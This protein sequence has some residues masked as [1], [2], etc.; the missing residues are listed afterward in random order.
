MD[1]RDAGRSQVWSRHWR[2]EVF[3]DLYGVLAT[4]PAF[5]RT[6]ADVLR[7]SPY[8]ATEAQPDALGHWSAYPTRTLR[9]RL[10]CEVLRSLPDEAG[11]AGTF[12]AEADAIDAEW[13]AAHPLHAM[14]AFD[15]DVKLVV[16]AM[17]CRPM[18]A[19]AASPGGAARPIASAL[20]FTRKM[21]KAAEADAAQVHEREN[22][23]AEDVRTLFAS[24]A[25]AFMKDPERYRSV[26]AHERFR[27]RL[28]K[29]PQRRKENAMK[30]S[31]AA[32]RAASVQALF[33]RVDASPR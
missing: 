3:A 21:H 31:S 32:R 28:L 29:L 26:G 18:Q 19:F 20:N 16:Q 33:D 13:E 17:L 22:P 1:V 30:L 5:V 12:A 25:L 27:A 9:L 4:G 23:K 2:S 15:G 10:A 7:G 6:L 8:I 11:A 24:V 14:A